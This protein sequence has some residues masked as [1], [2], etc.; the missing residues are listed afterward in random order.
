MGVIAVSS[1]DTSTI[2]RPRGSTVVVGASVDS[3][4]VTTSGSA[5]GVASGSATGATG[6]VVL[7]VVVT[8]ELEIA[9]VAQPPSRTAP[10]TAREPTRNGLWSMT[11][12]TLVAL[13]RL[14]ESPPQRAEVVD[15]DRVRAEGTR[16]ES[17]CL[18]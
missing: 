17:L 4:A 12:P 5:T 7:V 10:I 16:I 15:H 11:H 18:R 13:S 8:M 14:A 9:V 6:G 3:G 2:S 1:A